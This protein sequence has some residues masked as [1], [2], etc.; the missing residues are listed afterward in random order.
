MSAQSKTAFNILLFIEAVLIH[1]FT[2]AGMSAN[3]KIPLSQLFAFALIVCSR[4]IST[5]TLEND[6][7]V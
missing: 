2:A 6:F 4:A 7:P 3:A 5:G 1:R